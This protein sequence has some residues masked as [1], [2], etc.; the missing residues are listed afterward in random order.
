MKPITET[1]ELMKRTA[2]N[3]T[4]YILSNWDHD[5]FIPFYAAYKSSALA[6]FNRDHIVISADTGYLKPQRAIF[7]WFLSHKQLDPASCLFLDDQEEN[8][9][10]ALALGI[11]A[12]HIRLHD[13][14]PVIAYLTKEGLL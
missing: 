9:E 12:L 14:E 3:N 2:Q 4:H 10:A 13:L 11:K 8:I 7:E 1:I 6:P 5:S